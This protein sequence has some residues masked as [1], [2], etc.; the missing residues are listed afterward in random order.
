M[1]D[2]DEF[3]ARHPR[4]EHLYL[5]TIHDG[6]ASGSCVGQ[7]ST[8][9]VACDELLTIY[10]RRAE[11]LARFETQHA[12]NLRRDVVRFCEQLES[13]R[14]SFARWWTFT[15]PDGVHYEFVEDTATHQLLGALKAIS[16]LEVDPEEWARLWDR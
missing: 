7:S 11:H 6:V 4:T 8:S 5:A 13:A 12:G 15:M 16:K 2:C 14:G 10:R 3:L 9:A 1:T